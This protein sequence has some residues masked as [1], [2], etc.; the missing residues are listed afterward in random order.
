[1]IKYNEIK[2]IAQLLLEMLIYKDKSFYSEAEWRVHDF[3]F[4]TKFRVNNNVIIPYREIRLPIDA[5]KS[6]TIG[7]KCDYDKNLF[8]IQRLLKSKISPFQKVKII[9]STVPLF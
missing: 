2:P 9:K 7:P 6:I 8:S 5:L 3:N 1:M 4:E